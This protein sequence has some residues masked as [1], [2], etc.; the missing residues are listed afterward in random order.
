MCASTC[1]FGKVVALEL[2]RETCKS[3]R[4][5]AGEGDAKYKT[6]VN[7]EQYRQFRSLFASVVN[8]FE[9]DYT[10]FT[11]KFPSLRDTI[12]KWSRVKLDEKKKKTTATAIAF[13]IKAM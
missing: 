5:V 11:K 10:K 3:L 1:G 7:Q 6:S 2:S 9:I 8:N 13:R 12:N 4:R